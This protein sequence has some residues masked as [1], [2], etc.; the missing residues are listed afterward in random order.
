MNKVVLDAS[1]LLAY[2]LDEPGSDR[3]AEALSSGVFV[4]AVN[5]CEVLSK[6]EDRGL[7]VD[8][9][10]EAMTSQGIMDALEIVAFDAVLARET[11]SLRA[12]TREA[13]LSLGDR[14]CMAL[15]KTLAVPAL[16]ADRTWPALPGVEVQLI[17]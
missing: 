15:A 13:G 3:V 10:L 14:A 7:G 2:L 5:Q 17:R 16:T 6:L 1:A 12:A 9:A 11:A 4:C 8:Q